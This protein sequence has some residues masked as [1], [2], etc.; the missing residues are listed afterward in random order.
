MGI[1]LK[2]TDDMRQQLS[3]LLVTKCNEST[4][5]SPLTEEEIAVLQKE[6]SFGYLS[7]STIHTLSSKCG[8]SLKSFLKGSCMK[9][10]QS[11]YDDTE[12]KVCIPSR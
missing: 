7:K 10:S 8:I 5:Q 6:I 3:E 1:L 2:V 9:S 4:S 11:V 12:E